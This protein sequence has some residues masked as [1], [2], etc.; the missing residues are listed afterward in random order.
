MT[1]ASWRYI[2]ILYVSA[3]NA[4]FL[5]INRFVSETTEDRHVYTGVV[6]TTAQSFV[7]SICHLKV[8]FC[9]VLIVYIL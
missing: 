5:P 8:Q 3:K 1:I 4:H 6:L 9:C 2:N 7:L